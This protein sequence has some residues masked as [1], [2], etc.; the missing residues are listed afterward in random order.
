M[1]RGPGGA[2][3]LTSNRGRLVNR[4]ESCQ[5]AAPVPLASAASA[6]AA[7]APRWLLLLPGQ[8]ESRVLEAAA[9]G[10]WQLPQA[11]PTAGAAAPQPADPRPLFATHPG[12]QS[13]GKWCAPG[14]TVPTEHSWIDVQHGPAQTRQ[15]LKEQQSGSLLISGGAGCRQSPVSQQQAQQLTVLLEDQLALVIRVVLSPAA[16]LAALACSRAGSGSG[17]SVGLAAQKLPL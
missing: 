10:C 13:V 3:Q 6:D 7:A 8:P 4:P 2:G 1:H 5:T 12:L 17:G 11:Q 9:E 15:G 14:V 16:V